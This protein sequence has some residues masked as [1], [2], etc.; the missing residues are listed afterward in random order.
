[1]HVASHLVG[2]GCSVM[3]NSPFLV[4]VSGG[5]ENWTTSKVETYG[6]LTVKVGKNVERRTSILRCNPEKDV[7]HK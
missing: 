4:N 6:Q 3:L 7:V 2:C 5:L 1:M